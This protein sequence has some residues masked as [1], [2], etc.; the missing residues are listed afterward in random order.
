MLRKAVALFLIA[1][2]LQGCG[3]KGGLYLPESKPAPPQVPD[4]TRK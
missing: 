2:A 3:T 1:I 4:N